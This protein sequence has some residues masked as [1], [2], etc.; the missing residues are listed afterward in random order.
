MYLVI[1]FLFWFQFLEVSPNSLHSLLNHCSF[2]L[3]ISLVIIVSC[4]LF[5]NAVKISLVI[6]TFLGVSL[7]CFPSFTQDSCNPYP[8]LIHGCLFGL[9]LIRTYLVYLKDVS[10]Q[11]FGPAVPETITLNSKKIKNMLIIIMMYGLKI[12][13]SDK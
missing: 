3:L 13:P 11:P 9:L 2:A 12:Y 8:Q 4:L 7:F 10:H 6:Y 5:S 1:V